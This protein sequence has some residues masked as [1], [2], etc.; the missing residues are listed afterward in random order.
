[1]TTA[2]GTE[3]IE[4]YLR[5]RQVRYFRG[6]HDDEFFFL[7]NTY[8]GR[9]H[10]HLE[11]C[12]PAAKTVKISVTAERYYPIDQCDRVAALAQQWNNTGPRVSALVF[13]SSDPGLVGVVAESRFRTGEIEFGAF[14][15]QAIQSAIELFARMKASVGSAPDGGRLLDA[16]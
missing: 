14:A 6:H 1:M 2:I 5:T 3:L 10:V 15:D 9:L 13:E 16:S 4:G 7:V 12:G 11:P 8:H